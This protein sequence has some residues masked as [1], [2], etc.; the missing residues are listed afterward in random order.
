VKLAAQT[1]MA[2]LES[3]GPFH[4][5]QPSVCVVVVSVVVLSSYS[6]AGVSGLGLANRVPVQSSA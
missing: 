6:H 4:T 3:A 2:K 5:N 1:W